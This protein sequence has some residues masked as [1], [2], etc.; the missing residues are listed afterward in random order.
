M[1]AV[2]EAAILRCVILIHIR[3]PQL[4]AFTGAICQS[5]LFK[6]LIIVSQV[7]AYFYS[8]RSVK[9]ETRILLII[10]TVFDV[11]PSTV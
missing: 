3:T 4:K 10:V 1:C 7:I 6:W 2:C 8:F 5:P 11:Y 9:F